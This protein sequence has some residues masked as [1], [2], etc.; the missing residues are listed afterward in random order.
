MSI[1]SEIREWDGK[2]ADDIRAIHHRHGKSKNYVDQLV[3][4]FQNSEVRTGATW[5][6]KAALES[7]HAISRNHISRVYMSLGKLDCWEQKLH[8]LQC[9]EFMP[10]ESK[11]KNDLAGF[12]QRCLTDEN[13][14]V[15]A[16]A[17]SGYYYLAKQHQEFQEAAAQFFEIAL[18]DEAA[19]IK[20]RVRKVVKKGF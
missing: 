17:Y 8:V 9:I 3:K 12:L 7:G 6:L 5:L 16:W 2:S 18:R 20:A 19:S 13:K 1:E 10:I 15:R 4:L 14:F 11:H